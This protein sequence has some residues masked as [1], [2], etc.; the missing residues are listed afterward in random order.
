MEG[1][2]KKWEEK[3]KLDKVKLSSQSII[4]VPLSKEE[5]IK[6]GGGSNNF[7]VP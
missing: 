2:F 4:G 3:K 5:L 6:R 7:I 1:L